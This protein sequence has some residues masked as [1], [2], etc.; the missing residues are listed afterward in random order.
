MPDDRSLMARLFGRWWTGRTPDKYAYADLRLSRADIDR[1]AY[2][3]HLGGGAEKWD[4]RGQFQVFLLQSL[5]MRPDQRLLDAGC[6]P[7]RA[8]VH[9]IDHLEA[10]RYFGIDFNRDFIRVAR[11]LVAA[12][13]RLRGKSPRLEQLTEFAFQR[14]ESTFDW[15]LAFSVLNHCTE[16]SRALFFRNVL[17]VM[18]PAARLV[19]THAHWLVPA[20]FAT[21]PLRIERLLDGPDDLEPG[22]DIEAWGFASPPEGQMFPIAVFAR[23]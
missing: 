19:I 12:D 13:A 23:R 17:P 20:A 1:E 5:G 2:K 21:G 14:L 7:L 3:E 9:L 8:G 22:L 10:G 6:G 15:V 16:R 4:R 18:A 11:E